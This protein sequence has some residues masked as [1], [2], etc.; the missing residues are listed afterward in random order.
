M[1]LDIIVG[2]MFAGKSSRILSIASRYQA[3]HMSI[4]VI[5]HD[6][7]KRYEHSESNVVTHDNRRV[8]C[9]SVSDLNQESF[10]ELAN[11]Y[12]VLIV[13]EAQFFSDLRSF[14]KWAVDSQEKNV[15]LMGLDG[16][17]NR[18]MFGEILAC[19]PLADRVEKLSGYCH[20]CVN[21]TPGLFSHR[22]SGVMGDQVLVGG[23]EIYETLCRKC[24]LEN[25]RRKK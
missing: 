20:S 1:S 12:Q 23:H 10:R 24:F 5:K 17:S 8:P 18:E 2:P 19:I 13:D 4:L 22:R 15:Y 6:N 3:I 7:D 14:V 11:N 25:T 16:D 21:G 9:V